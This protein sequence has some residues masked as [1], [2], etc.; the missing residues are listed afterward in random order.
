MKRVP[1]IHHIFFA[2]YSVLGVY[3]QN[4]VQVP[5]QWVVRPLVLM[6]V[7][8][9]ITFHILQSRL[10]NPFY[11][12]YLV[13]L[14]LFWLFFGHIQ[15]SL[16]E[17]SSFWGTAMGSVL[18][19]LAWTIPLVLIGSPW[20]W[21]HIRNPGLVTSFLNITAVFVVL[22]PAYITGEAYLQSL[23]QS[24]LYKLQKPVALTVSTDQATPPDVYIIILDAY[25]RED[26]LQEVY[27]FDNREFIEGLRQRGFY[28]ADRSTTNY[29]Q[30]LLSLSSLL[31]IG[32]L[33]DLTKDIQGTEARGP[34]V[35]LVQQSIVRRSL[36]NVGYQFVAL[37][38]ATLST[39]MRDADIY[40]EMTAGDLNEF[41][42][43]LLSSTVANLAIATLDLNLPVPSYELHRRYI[44]FSLEQM[45]F[46]PEI[47]GPKF[48]FSHIMAPHPPFVLDEDGSFI[49][50]D[51]PFNTGDATGFAGT[52]EEYVAGYT[53]EIRYLNTRIL[54]AVDTILS[55]SDTPPIII[56]Q[57]DH[58]PGNYF[59]MV[60]QDNLCLRE[61]YSILNAYY[62]PDQDYDALYPTITPVNS[63]RIVFDRYFDADLQLLADVNYYAS[64]SAP[65]VFTDVSDQA[66]TCSIG[67]N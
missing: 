6:V 36:Q 1:V 49:E 38:S 2:I 31:N 12:G 61:R 9:A 32:Y 48:V 63:F 53:N 60:E 24:R 44:L 43:L 52:S 10:K 21:G 56:I 30:T 3:S 54:Q 65:Y 67:I 62:F 57:G 22:Y 14:G 64:W 42:G 25:G 59:N 20:A 34:L 47:A 23:R 27:G 19:F 51:R 18:A 17:T 4:S 35:N 66:Q 46:V 7:L 50:S 11:T 55:Q 45:A 26:F 5:V 41:E 29:P 16:L 13:T 28:V 58:G 40:I 33:N 8:S 37:P 15:R 39:Q